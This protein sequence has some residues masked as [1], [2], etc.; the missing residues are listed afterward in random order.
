MQ[1]VPQPEQV[2]S[3][4]AG[5]NKTKYSESY[6]LAAQQRAETVLQAFNESLNIAKKSKN[7]GV[8]EYRLQIAREWLIELKKLTIKFPF[9]SLQ[10]LQA[11]EA[12]IIAVEVETRSLPYSEVV[13]TSIKDVPDKVRPEGSGQV[14]QRL[15]EREEQVI[16]MCIQSCF[17]VVNESIAIARKSK[18]RDTQ[19]SRLSVARDR[20]KEAQRQAR[21]FSLEVG[22][23]V[24]AEAEINRIDE[25]IRVGTSTEIAGMQQIDVNAAY[26]SAARNL[27]MEATALKREKKYIEA[28][29][30]LREA[31]S[32]D[33]AENLFIEERLRLP[34]YLQLAGK[35]DE[36]WDELNRL[37]ASYDQS[38]QPRIEHQMKVF[39]RKENNETAS[40]PVRVILRGDNKPIAMTSA[41]NGKTINE[42]QNASSPIGKTVGELQS[43]PM[44]AWGKW[45]NVEIITGLEF[46]AT[47]QLRTPVRVLLRHGEIHTDRN[48]K[49]PEIVR[50]GWEGSWLPKL[51]TFREIGLDMDEPPPR[52]HAS[53]IGP[54]VARDYLPF[55]IAI[56]EI[57]ELNESIENRIDKLREMLSVC[58]WQEFL[59]KHGGTE[60]IVQYFFPRY[61][62]SMPT[63]PP[64]AMNEFVRLGYFN[65]PSRIAAATDEELL[66]IKGIGPAKLKAI[67]KHFADIAK[68]RDADR[69]ENVI[70]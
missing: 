50:E 60:K 49:P 45:G 53:S 16:L 29:D 10:N 44:S 64:S 19:L 2:Q 48:T 34:M 8:R 32:A 66:S 42:M 38:F 47:M 12:D 57:V 59:G 24:E 26:S 13:D 70:R 14:R 27:L 33:G 23:F 41:S 7:R 68:H 22:G 1:S 46:S 52:A 56:R 58:D 30:K 31:Y 43:E 54:I 11:V 69:V 21:Q 20:L 18:N 6:V 65:T 63:L 4:K 35:N 51:K 3:S 36:G 37:Y 55:L 67:R 15:S 61:I 62:E 25:A 40:N 17:K 28:C 39:L 5:D 9:L